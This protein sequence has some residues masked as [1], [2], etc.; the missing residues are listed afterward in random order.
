[1][2]TTIDPPY[3]V[4]LSNNPFDDIVEIEISTRGKHSTLGIQFETNN[5]LGDR[6]Q[7]TNMLPSTPAARIPR[8]RSTLRQSFPINIGDTPISNIKD[9]EDAVSVTRKQKLPTIKLTFGLMNK[10]AMHPQNGFPIIFH[11]QLNVISKHLADIK[12]DSEEKT[13][14]IKN[15][16]MQYYQQLYYR[17]ILPSELIQEV[18]LRHF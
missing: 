15:I 4:S 6:L 2:N 14:S 7:V 1:M 9:I 11:D 16:L 13:L 12:Q 3:H 18:V 10:T 8:W 17:Q 5:T